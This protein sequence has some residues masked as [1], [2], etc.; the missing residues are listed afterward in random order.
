VQSFYPVF[1]LLFVEESFSSGEAH[2]E[3]WRKF[4]NTLERDPRF[5]K[6]LW[7]SAKQGP[8][9]PQKV[10]AI[11]DRRQLLF[12]EEFPPSRIDAK[13]SH[14]SIWPYVIAIWLMFSGA[15]GPFMLEHPDLFHRVGYAVIGLL[16]FLLGVLFF[17][18]GI[19]QGRET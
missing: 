11:N 19:G 10:E 13:A 14:P 6:I 5:H 9:D 2:V 15:I 16:L 18:I 1:W 17:L 4:G 8:P 7:R 3:L 12:D